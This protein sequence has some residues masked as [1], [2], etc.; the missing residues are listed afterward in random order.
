MRNQ[1]YRSDPKLL[2][3]ANEMRTNYRSMIPMAGKPEPV[4]AISDIDIPA[5]APLRMLRARVYTPFSMA[6]AQDGQR[7]GIVLYTHG[8]GFVS[9]DLDTHDVMLRALANRS[10]CTVVSLDYRLAPEAP[11]P[12]GLEDTYAA[13]QWLAVHGGEIGGDPQSIIVA[14]D[15]AGG[16]LAAAVCLMARDQGGPRV[17]A[18]VLLYANTGNYGETES[19]KKLSD[20][21][22]PTR[23]VMELVLQCY[24]PES[25]TQHHAPMT[26]PLRAE[27]EA[28]PPALIIT[29]EFDPIKDE[30]ALYAQKL[31]AAGVVV[32]EDTYYDVEH[33]FIQYFQAQHNQPMGE[34]ALNQVANFIK[35]IFDNF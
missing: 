11:F 33:G 9:G 17:K 26:A 31:R 24:V 15:S 8:G 22:F 28:L 10:D 35:K 34:Q 2:A 5:D 7:R 12:A 27:L 14:G 3:F 20:R 23:D 19:W 21:R 18:Q 30:G 4:S 16:N 13:L 32:E 6:Q 25:P 1:Q 29:A